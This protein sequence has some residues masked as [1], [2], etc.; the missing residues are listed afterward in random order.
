M[1]ISIDQ[2]PTAADISENI[3]Q[4]GLLGQTVHIT[5]MDVK[6]AKCD[7]ARLQAQA[8]V[9][10][11]VLGA[12]LANVNCKSFETWGIF[13]G[14]TWIGSDQSPLLF[15]TQWAPKPA[16]TAVLSTLQHHAAALRAAAAL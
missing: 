13:D 16:Y 7:A 12:C 15:D 3:R 1:H 10:A 4:L 8:Q 11:D 14:D 9:Y 6:C 2:A 5:E